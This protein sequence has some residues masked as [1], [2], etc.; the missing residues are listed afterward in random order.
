M[1]NLSLIKD[2]WCWG[3]REKGGFGAAG[4]FR[5]CWVMK[6]VLIRWYFLIGSWI[7]SSASEVLIVSRWGNLTGNQWKVGVGICNHIL[8]LRYWLGNCI[9]QRRRSIVLD[10][11]APESFQIEK[12]LR[13]LRKGL[14]LE[15]QFFTHSVGKFLLAALGLVDLCEVSY[16]DCFFDM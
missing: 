7:Q 4:R 12:N 13:I 5:V 8:I 9:T 10:T 1:H 11:V 16:F 6:P 14:V 3:W 15:I 2:Q